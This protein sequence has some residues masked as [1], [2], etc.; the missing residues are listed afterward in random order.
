MSLL[1]ALGDR[2]MGLDDPVW[3]YVPAWRHEPL[4][5]KIT[6][7]HLVTHSSGLHFGEDAFWPS[8]LSWMLR[9]LGVNADPDPISIALHDTPVLFQ[10]GT[11]F[12]YSG[13]GFAVLGYAITAS[14]KDAP[15]K[16]IRTLFRDRIMKPLGI[17]DSEWS[18]PQAHNLD[19]MS[20]YP[21]W[22]GGRYTARAVARIGQLMLQKGQWDGRQLVDR[23]WV[24]KMVSYSGG[25][26][27]EGSDS[28][29]PAHGLCWVVNFDGVWPSVPRDAFLG[30]P[31]AG[32]QIL[33]VIPSLE[34]VAVRFGT[35]LGDRGDSFWSAVVEH[36]L[37][38]LL[39]AFDHPAGLAQRAS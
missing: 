24:E 26:L 9:K 22:S 28:F 21:I 6:I 10:P 27:P 8:R 15:Y 32:Q 33:I 2:R 5:S 18:L 30:N 39:K 34:L 3:K 25:P 4:K 38:P 35:A 19:D 23:T 17:P 20:V 16:D 11:R 13:T 1:V 12:M 14:L 7:R 29:E 37:N 36:L 31:G